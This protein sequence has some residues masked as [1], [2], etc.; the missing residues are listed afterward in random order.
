MVLSGYIDMMNTLW[1]GMYSIGR[2]TLPY[3]NLGAYLRYIILISGR[4]GVGPASKECELK[5]AKA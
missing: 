2:G 3:F 5:D 1:T 4:P